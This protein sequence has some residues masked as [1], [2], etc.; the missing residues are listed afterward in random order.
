ME[1][2]YF[3]VPDEFGLQVERV[4]DGTYGIYFQGSFISTFE[5][6]ASNLG[7]VGFFP[8]PETDG[9]TG[10]V[11]Y[12]IMPTDTPYPEEARQL[13]EFLASAEAQAIMVQQG[14]F[15]APHSDVPESAYS[16]ID[17]EV[18]R[19]MRT[20]TVVPDLD[21]AIGPPFQTTFWDQLKALWVTPNMD[22]DT[23]LQDLQDD[24]APPDF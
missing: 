20:V 15:L 13:V 19:F 17:L 14:G 10:S 5:P 8:F 21:D 4:W 1:A 3:S 18:L 12:A 22:L 9:A 11:D 2:G 7:D 16:T 6:F 23:M 24:W